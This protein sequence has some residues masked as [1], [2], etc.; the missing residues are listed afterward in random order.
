MKDNPD[1][2]IREILARGI[3]NPALWNTKSSTWNPESTARNPEPKTVLDPFTW[4]EK[5]CP[6][7]QS[8]FLY[9]KFT[10]KDTIGTL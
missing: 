7:I 8:G 5:I 2:E 9:G 6:A 3:R 10:P 1:S 4:G